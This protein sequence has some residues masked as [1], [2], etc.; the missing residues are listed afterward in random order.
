GGRQ[1]LKNPRTRRPFPVG[2]GFPPRCPAQSTG[3][4]TA[5]AGKPYLF[6]CIYT[7]FDDQQFTVMAPGAGGGNNWNPASYNPNTGYLYVCLKE[8]SFGYKSIPDASSLDRGCRT[9][10]DHLFAICNATTTTGSLVVAMQ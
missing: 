9:F 3:R 6:G 2:D 10:I 4:A 1:G 8:T 7:P 5:A